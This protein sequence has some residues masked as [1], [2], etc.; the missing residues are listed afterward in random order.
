MEESKFLEIKDTEIFVP[1][2]KLPGLEVGS[3]GRDIRSHQI[4]SNDRPLAEAALLKARKEAREKAKSLSSNKQSAILDAQ[5]KLSRGN[6]RLTDQQVSSE[7]QLIELVHTKDP[8]IIGDT[9]IQDSIKKLRKVEMKIYEG[10]SDF[11]LLSRDALLKIA[12]SLVKPADLEDKRFSENKVH[13][14]RAFWLGFRRAFEVVI[15]LSLGA[16]IAIDLKASAFKGINNYRTRNQQ[17]YEAGMKNWAQINLQDIGSTLSELSRGKTGVETSAVEKQPESIIFTIRNEMK[18][19]PTDNEETINTKID[20]FI[21]SKTEGGKTYSLNVST[22]RNVPG[23]IIENQTAGETYSTISLG[24]G[25]PSV[26]NFKLLLT[27]EM[28]QGIQTE[29][30]KSGYDKSLLGK[31]YAVVLERMLNNYPDL[32]KHYVGLSIGA[33][34]VNFEN[35]VNNAYKDTY[36]QNFD[37]AIAELKGMDQDS[38]IKLLTE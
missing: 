25:M 14:E 24:K 2:K 15:V 4:S 33:L 12:G 38:L 30:F 23:N 21:A 32:L 17:R 1:G 20:N 29:N 31:Q 27:W 16:Q 8:D 34:D 28:R 11:R 19:S 22:L 37:L 3:Q 35:K 5:S 26:N 36:N 10:I 13:R 7:E 18:I 6:A 9:N